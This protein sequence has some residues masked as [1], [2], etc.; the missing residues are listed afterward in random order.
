MLLRT[1]P[2]PKSSTF[3]RQHVSDNWLDELLEGSP[4]ASDVRDVN[5]SLSLRE[6]QKSGKRFLIDEGQTYADSVVTQ[7]LIWL[8]SRNMT[9]S[10]QLSFDGFFFLPL[11]GVTG[12]QEPR[13]VVLFMFRARVCTLHTSE[14]APFFQDLHTI[15]NHL[16]WHCFKLFGL[17]YASFWKYK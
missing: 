14:S 12:I 7:P 3:K 8:W 11:R 13:P 1:R 2:R 6:R 17:H 5:L 16:A 15:I 4:K 9:K 10:L